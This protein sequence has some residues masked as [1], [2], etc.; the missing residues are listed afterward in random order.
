M[1]LIL[2]GLVVVDGGLWDYDVEYELGYDVVVV[3]VLYEVKD[4]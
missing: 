1:I 2:C 3:V 4:V